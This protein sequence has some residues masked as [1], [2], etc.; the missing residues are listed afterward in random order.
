MGALRMAWKLQRWEITTLAAVGAVLAVT[1]LAVGWR[2]ES[3]QASAP[4]CWQTDVD[5]VLPQSAVNECA[6]AYAEH[7][8]ARTIGSMAGAGVVLLPFVLGVVL[9]TPV[10]ARE[11]EAR[12]A[13]IAWSVSRSRGRWLALRTLPILAFVVLG[14]AVIGLSSLTLQRQLTGG[15]VGFG[16]LIPQLPVLLARGLLALAVGLVAGTLLGR[17]LPAVL[18]SAVFLIAISIGLSIGLDVWMS[19]EAKPIAE[20]DGTSSKVYNSG[21]RDDATGEL[22]NLDAFL[23]REDADDMLEIPPPG[24]TMVHWQIPGSEYPVWMARE[25]GVTGGLAIVAG[26]AFVLTALRR[27]P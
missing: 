8:A 15:E 6:Q 27:R 23:A 5:A 19:A 20:L 7:D 16:S 11:I 18:A 24:M 4:D 25:A 12:T 13:S 22:I 3:V 17:T 26:V 9:G 10:V 21:L 14:I 1:L 2:M